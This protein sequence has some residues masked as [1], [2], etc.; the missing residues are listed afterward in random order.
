MDIGR[1]EEWLYWPP[2][3]GRGTGWPPNWTDAD[4]D[5]IA[6]GRTREVFPTLPVVMERRAGRSMIGESGCETANWQSPGFASELCG[7]GGRSAG[8]TWDLV[9]S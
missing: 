1:L 8:T 2:G 3:C 7:I 6:S 9:P 5:R 4:K